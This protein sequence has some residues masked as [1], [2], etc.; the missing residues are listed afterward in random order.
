MLAIDFYKPTPTLYIIM[1]RK[2]VDFSYR[3]VTFKLGFTEM[4]SGDLRR[5]K[6]GFIY[7]QL[8]TVTLTWWHS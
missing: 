6:K 8:I 2:P 7:V 5:I 3:Q 1:R 4:S